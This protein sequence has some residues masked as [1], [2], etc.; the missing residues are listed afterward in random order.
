MMKDKKKR[1]IE[2]K[3]VFRLLS[4]FLKRERKVSSKNYLVKAYFYDWGR[5]VSCNNKIHDALLDFEIYLDLK[6]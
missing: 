1:R 3:G 5:K 2:A 6:K 4:G